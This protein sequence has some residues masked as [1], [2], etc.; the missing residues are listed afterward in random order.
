MIETQ[1]FEVMKKYVVRRELEAVQ[2]D[3]NL[4]AE[5][6]DWLCRRVTGAD[7]GGCLFF[8]SKYVPLVPSRDDKESFIQCREDFLN[9]RFAVPRGYWIVKTEDGSGFDLAGDD[10]FQDL[11]D[12]VE[13]SENE[14]EEE[15]QQ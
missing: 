4:T 6:E 9:T 10:D 12:P 1:E 8:R 2:W 3:G 15:S 7:Q 13:A 11:F 14:P 5:L